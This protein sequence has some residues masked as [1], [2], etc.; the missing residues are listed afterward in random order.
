MHDCIQ[1]IPLLLAMNGRV[2]TLELLEFSPTAAAQILTH[3]SQK[4]KK[5]QAS[6]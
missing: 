6:T 3:Q 1:I 2:Y 5:T 4:R